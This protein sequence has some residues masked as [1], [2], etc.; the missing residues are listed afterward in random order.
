MFASRIPIA[1]RRVRPL[2]VAALAAVLG[3]AAAIPAARA[4]SSERQG[5]GGATELLIPVGA[6]GVA[7]GP[8][9]AGTASGVDALYWNPAG[10]AR[11]EGTEALFS[12]TQYFADMKLN[13][14]AV[15]FRAGN[16][17]VLGFGAK[18]LS[19]GDVVVTTEQAPDGTGE[20]LN[21][22]FSVLGLSW[23][24][25]FTDRVNFGAT[26]NYVNERIASMNASGLALDF[27]AQYDTGWRGLGLSI[28]MKNFGGAMAFDGEDLGVSVLPPGAEPSA[29]NRIV[30]FTTAK[31]EMPSFF[32][33]GATYEV[34][35]QNAQSLRLMGAFQNNNFTGDHV[36]G[37]AEWTYRD[38]YALRGSWF[39]SLN[40]TT[41]PVTG[42]DHGSIGSGDDLFQGVALGAGLT[43]KSGDSRFGLDVAWRPVRDFFNDVFEG[44]LTARF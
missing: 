10:L 21:P 37:A 7:L 2:L 33:L 32:S 40:S 42:E 17:G 5:T 44:T 30:K 23:G 11:L 9:Y 15:G 22:T 31:F 36:T 14:A 29:S 28:A 34:Y 1:A 4:G 41:D 27:G 38:A 3:V 43:F 20:I 13:Y 24:R 26:V 8:G 35:R 18:V 39:G 25:A 12:H 19:A 16:L 6:R